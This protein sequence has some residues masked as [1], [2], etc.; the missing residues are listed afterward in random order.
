[1]DFVSISFSNLKKKNPRKSTVAEALR[2]L[3][4]QWLGKLQD[5]TEAK[6]L[7]NHLITESPNNLKIMQ[8][9]LKRL[10]DNKVTLCLFFDII[11]IGS[12]VNL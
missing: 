4:V 10:F 8:A 12:L 11:F 6:D 3:Y 9:Y 7:Y 1:M 5:D 2:S